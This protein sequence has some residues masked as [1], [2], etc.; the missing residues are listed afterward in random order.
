MED[1]RGEPE[2]HGKERTGSHAP[3]MEAQK[4][5]EWTDNLGHAS[6]AEVPVDSVS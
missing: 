6:C 4:V 1:K 2:D 3:P 5:F